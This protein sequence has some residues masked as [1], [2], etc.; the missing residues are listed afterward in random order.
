MDDSIV[1]QTA[2]SNNEDERAPLGSF[3]QS[4]L[5][6]DCVLRLSLP[7]KESTCGCNSLNAES[8]SLEGLAMLGDELFERHRR[9]SSDLLDQ[10]IRAGED[11]VLVIECD[12]A[13]V[14]E[15]EIVAFSS[16]GLGG[17]LFPGL[18]GVFEFLEIDLLVLDVLSQDPAQDVRGL[19]VRVFERAEERV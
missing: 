6:D 12:L 19:P 3:G 5:R 13:Q 10:V 15:Q 11:A 1:S 16:L 14:L 17:R 8:L 2:F 4:D 9:A 18:Q 7:T